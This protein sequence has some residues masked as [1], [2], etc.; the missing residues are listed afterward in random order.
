MSVSVLLVLIALLL[1]IGSFFRPQWPLIAVAVL[2]VCVAMLVG[3]AG[4]IHLGLA[5]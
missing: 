5:P 1:A 3:S 2:L 4:M